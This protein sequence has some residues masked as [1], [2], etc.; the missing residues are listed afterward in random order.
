MAGTR[1]AQRILALVAVAGGL[2]LGCRKEPPMP[3]E[4]PAGQAVHVDLDAMPYPTLSEYRFFVGDLSERLPNT[5]VLPYAPIT[6]LFS[7]YASKERF[8]WMPSGGKAQY[9]SDDQ[10]LQFPEGTVLIK[11]FWYEQVQ[12]NNDR[13][14]LE[15]RLMFRRNGV[16]VFA[17]YVWN[18][19]QSEAFLDLNGSYVPLDHLDDGGT[20]R[21]VDYRIPSLAECHTCH[22]SDN[23]PIPIGPKPQN[24]DMTVTYADGP[25]DQLSRWVA[26]GYLEAGYPANIQHVIAWDDATQDLQLRVRSY[27]DANCA[28]CHNEHGHCEYRP[29]RFAFSMTADIANIGVCVAPEEV[30]DPG[31]THIVEAGDTARS[32]LYHRIN[33]TN[34]AY[35]MPLM[36]RTVIHREAVA[37][38]GE[39]INGLTPPC[40]N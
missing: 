30:V 29:M 11:D 19:E 5:G 18:N 31:W 28:H 25:M 26:E 16:W 32:V 9:I 8:V 20:V 1:R 33:S 17:D 27:L 4:A 13:R 37:M 36:G 14:I 40:T 21:H 23:V 2:F 22:K 39:W 12:P 34:E 15:T 38:I 35:R 6:P 24:L 7:D 3:E 10:V